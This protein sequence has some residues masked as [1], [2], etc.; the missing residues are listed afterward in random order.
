[1]RLGDDVHAFERWV[2]YPGL[3]AGGGLD[4]MTAFLLETMTRSS[5]GWLGAR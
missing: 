3:F 4:V 5:D 2:T 1:M